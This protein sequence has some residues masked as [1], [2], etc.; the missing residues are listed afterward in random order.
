MT[1]QEKYTYYES[2]IDNTK[3]YTVGE[4]QKVLFEMGYSIPID[5]LYLAL[6]TTGW[7][8]LRLIRD[9]LLDLK[10]DM[11]KKWPFDSV[12]HIIKSPLLVDRHGDLN[13]YYS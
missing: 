9:K 12:R 13:S 5:D 1:P 2:R 4:L 10:K 7:V 11:P 8:K 3:L 6:K